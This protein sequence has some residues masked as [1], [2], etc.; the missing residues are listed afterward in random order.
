MNKNDQEQAKKVWNKPRLVS[1]GRI[2]EVTGQVGVKAGS[3]D[4]GTG[5]GAGIL[6]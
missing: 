2:R 6:S 4:D 5:R 3:P 1:H